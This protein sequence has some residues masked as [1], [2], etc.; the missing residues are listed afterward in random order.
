MQQPGVV[1]TELASHVC[2]MWFGLGVA[3][4]IVA[5]CKQH[6]TCLTSLTLL[7]SLTCLTNLTCLTTL[8]CITTLTCLSSLTNL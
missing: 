6:L 5:L 2:F 1:Y 3:F 4:A 7:T 8:T